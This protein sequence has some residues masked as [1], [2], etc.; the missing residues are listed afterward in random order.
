MTLRDRLLAVLVAVC[1]GMNFP[2]TS[3]ALSHFPP[4]LL[5][6]VRFALLAVPTLLFVKRPAVPWRWLVGYGLGFGV[7]QFAFLYWGMAAGMPS[8]LASLVLQAS[9]PFTVLLGAVWLRERL[10]AAQVLGILLAAAGM[11]LIAAHRSQSAAI[12]PFLLTLAGAL[13]WAFGNVCARQARPDSAVRLMLWMSVIPPVPMLALSLVVEGPRTDWQALVTAVRP[14]ALPAVGG[15]LYIVVVATVLGSGLWA[16]L[17]KRYPSSTVAP[18]SM[19]VPVV[20]IASSW[21][22]LGERTD[23]IELIGAGVVIAG[24]LIGSGLARRRRARPDPVVAP[25]EAASGE[26]RPVAS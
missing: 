24:V 8:G 21:L 20:G 5:V 22:V 6:A 3:L 9:A 4:M 15:L 26:R 10:G 1:W 13:G 25:A 2:A 19:L 17:L 23:A 18:F 16:A 14:E 12:L 7:L 11:V